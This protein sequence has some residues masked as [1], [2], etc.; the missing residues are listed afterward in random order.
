M[1][2]LVINRTG[3]SPRVFELS[4]DRPVSIGRAKSNNLI[5]DHGSVSRFHAVLHSAAGGQWQIIDRDSSNGVRVN[6]A[7][8]REATLQADDQI[9]IGEYSVQFED[10]VKRKITTCGTAKFPPKFAKILSEAAYSG[11]FMPVE[12]IAELAEPVSQKRPGAA[13]RLRALESENKLLALLYRLNQS[14]VEITNQDELTRRV[15]DFVLEIEGAE[16]SYMMLLDEESMGRNDLNIIGYSFQPA[17]IRYRNAPQGGDKQATPQ[18]AISQTIISQ[19]MKSGLPLLIAEGDADPRFSKSKSVIRSGMQSAMCAP[20]G[21]GNRVRGLL[22]VDNLSRRGMFAVDDL[23]A[24]SVI[25]VQ[26]GLAIERIRSR[27]EV[28]VPVRS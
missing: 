18:L 19:V 15:L 26:A 21:I 2:R 27:V 25:A 17:I 6:G 5:L 20:L 9:A 16:R 12:A 13:E 4:G 23:N 1:P 10:S 24:F 14:L 11:S 28:P 8:T 3:D 22:Y 7:A